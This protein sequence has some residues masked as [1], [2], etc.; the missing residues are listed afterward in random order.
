MLTLIRGTLN[1]STD[2]PPFHSQIYQ[3]VLLVNIINLNLV[4]QLFS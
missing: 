1:D 2:R 3:K 4:T